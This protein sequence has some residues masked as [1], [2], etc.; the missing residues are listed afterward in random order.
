VPGYLPGVGSGY[1]RRIAPRME[2]FRARRVAFCDIIKD[3]TQR[4]GS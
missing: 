4:S 3:N 1:G 2:L